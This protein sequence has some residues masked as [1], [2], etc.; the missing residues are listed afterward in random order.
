MIFIDV[1]RCGADGC[2]D[3]KLRLLAGMSVVLR[4]QQRRPFA[5]QDKTRPPHSKFT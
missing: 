4:P 2:E 3:G 5:A 1:L